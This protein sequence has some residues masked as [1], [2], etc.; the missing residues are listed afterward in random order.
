[1][2]VKEVQSI[3]LI[4]FIKNIHSKTLKTT[5]FMAAKQNKKII[6]LWE[7][8]AFV[9]NHGLKISNIQE[10]TKDLGSLLSKVKLSWNNDYFFKGYILISLW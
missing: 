8:K 5:E 9:N 2:W 7:F 1:M 3:F 6:I 4:F 10:Q